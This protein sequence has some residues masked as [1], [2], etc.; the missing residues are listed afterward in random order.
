MREP[1]TWYDAL[2]AG[3]L[4]GL[5]AWVVRD[6]RPIVIGFTIGRKVT[7]AFAITHYAGNDLKRKPKESGQGNTR[8]TTSAFKR[9]VKCLRF[10]AIQ[11]HHI[12]Y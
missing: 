3:D 10:R 8:G 12:P 4:S 9:R 6:D 1:L 5:G 11:L 7:F 2:E